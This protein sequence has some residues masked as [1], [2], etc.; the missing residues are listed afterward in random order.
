[1]IHI[2]NLVCN[3]IFLGRYNKEL[4]YQEYRARSLY[5]DATASAAN[6]TWIFKRKMEVVS[7]KR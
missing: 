7:R 2:Q 1:M 5:Q 4:L 6:K 3:N